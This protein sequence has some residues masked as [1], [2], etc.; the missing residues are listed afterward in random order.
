MDL[1]RCLRMGEATNADLNG[2]MD[3]LHIPSPEEPWMEG[4]PW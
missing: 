2:A 4:S 1:Y 3:I